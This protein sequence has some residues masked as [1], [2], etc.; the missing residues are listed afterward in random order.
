MRKS[1]LSVHCGSLG[2]QPHS[3]AVSRG[4]SEGSSEPCYS[5]LTQAR[6]SS[7]RTRLLWVQVGCTYCSSTVKIGHVVHW[8]RN[9]ML[10]WETRKNKKLNSLS[11]KML[12]HTGF[13]GLHFIPSQYPTQY[14]A[15][16]LLPLPFIHF[17]FYCG[18]SFSF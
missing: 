2:L 5:G 1:Y 10:V 18:F 4:R 6:R 16:Q 12:T 11:L 14:F 15:Y 9:K 3:D 13:L 8:L 7:N 17:I